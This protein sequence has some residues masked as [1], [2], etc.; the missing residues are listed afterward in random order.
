MSKLAA[1]ANEGARR[2]HPQRRRAIV[3]S[4]KALIAGLSFGATLAVSLPAVATKCLGE[5]DRRE[6]WTVEFATISR[7]DGG[8][9][10]S[11][12]VEAAWGDDSTKT[13]EAPNR[14]ELGAPLRLQYVDGD[15]QAVA[16]IDFA[17]EAL[18]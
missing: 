1:H 10:V 9:A 17:T 7:L 2:S 5:R 4:L 15:G 6:R 3:P 18:P 13:L 12:A 14:Y 8:G 16:R 11:P